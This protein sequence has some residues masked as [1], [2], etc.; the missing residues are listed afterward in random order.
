M[1]GS[2]PLGKQA[3]NE[4]KVASPQEEAN[5]GKGENRLRF[6]RGLTA[7]D[8]LLGNEDQLDA[9]QISCIIEGFVDTEFLWSLAVGAAVVGVEVD[10]RSKL[11]FM[12]RVMSY[13]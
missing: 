2:V 3:Q 6:V 4:D 5:K 11:Y 10:P 12:Q 1:L 8:V 7:E 13:S 9:I